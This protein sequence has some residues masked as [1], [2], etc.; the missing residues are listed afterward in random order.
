MKIREEKGYALVLS[1]L[2][3][4]IFMV[5][6]LS[7]L[8]A[9]YNNSKQSIKV[10]K[11]YQAVAVAEMGIPYYQTSILHALEKT[12]DAVLAEIAQDKNAGLNEEEIFNLM[13]TKF[14]DFLKEEKVEVGEDASFEL[15]RTISPAGDTGLFIEI[16][17]TGVKKKERFTLFAETTIPLTIM[18]AVNNGDSHTG[19]FLKKITLPTVPDSCK[20]PVSLNN[21]CKEVL[22]TTSK[23]Y[24]GNNMKIQKDLIYSQNDLTLTGNNNNL[25]NSSIHVDGQFTMGKNM[26]NAKNIILE[27]GKNAIFNGHF[28]LEGES[29]VYIGGDMKVGKHLNV[30]S[31]S[32]V[33]VAGKLEVSGHKNISGKLFIKEQNKQEFYANCAGGRPVEQPA[34]VYWSSD[35]EDTFTY[36]Y[37]EKDK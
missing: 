35:I 25:D 26:N 2:I 27:V 17:S 31:G 19:D 20:N 10:E 23:T 29:E 33:C 37:E 3:I 9:S 6:A 11:N 36:Y 16:T 22:L 15:K 5:V 13:I 8:A 24:L 34:S 32:K 30:S 18:P 7:L 12:R 14:P 1:L 4:T 21:R 28:D